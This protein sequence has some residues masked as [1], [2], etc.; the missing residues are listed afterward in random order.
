[1]RT[2][3]LL[4]KL[5]AGL[6]VLLLI[7]AGAAILLLPRLLPAERV[8]AMAQEQAQK[9]LHRQVRLGEVSLSLWK[10]IGLRELEL[11]ESPDFSAGTFAAVKELTL[12]P[13]L[14]AL[15]RKQLLID[16]VAIEGLK[17]TLVK[18]K[19]GSFNFSSLGASDAGQDPQTGSGK[20]L[21]GGAGAALALDIRKAKL[22]KS[23]ALYKDLR[24]GDELSLSGMDATL[25]DF[26]LSKP[27]AAQLRLSAKGRVQGR[28]LNGGLRFDG[29]VD[30]G[31]QDPDRLAVF[32]NDLE[33]QQAELRLEASGQ[34]RSL[35]APRFEL[36]AEVKAQGQELFEGDFSG[37]GDAQG[38]ASLKFALRSRGF[39][40]DI[41]KSLGVKGGIGVPRLNAQGAL[42]W[43][44]ARLAL[45]KV[46]LESTPYGNV[47][48]DGEIRGL[49]G[50][51]PFPALDWSVALKIPAG[52][53]KDLGL[54]FPDGIKLPG[55]A[56]D[57]KGRISGD[58]LNV[59]RFRLRTEGGNDV[60]LQG[61]ISGL[62]AAR[63]QLNV[64]VKADS[65]NL[66]ELAQLSP[67]ARSMGLKGRGFFAVAARGYSDRPTLH[68][69]IQFKG[70]G[71][72]A[73]A[74]E[75]SDFAGIAIFDSQRI[76]IPDLKGRVGEGVL[77]LDLTVR[78]YAQAPKIELQGELSR[79]DL[80]KMQLAQGGGKAG[81]AVEPPGPARP[82]PTLEAKGKFTVKEVVHPNAQ[83][84]DMELR[85]DLS[86]VTSDLR[87]LSGWAKMKTGGGRFSALSEM[88]MRSKIIKVLVM[89]LMVFQKVGSLGG[90]RIIPDLNNIAFTELSGDYSFKQGM[91]TIQESRLESEAANLYA[92]GD[93]DL[94]AERLNLAVTAQVAGLNPVE[95]DVRGTF[96]EPSAKPRLGKLLADP[97]KQ[98][99]EKTGKELL[100]N[101]FKRR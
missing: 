88:T 1:M 89:P 96:S 11:S 100:E 6:A 61:L 35:S 59:E 27:F 13:D 93:I 44:G 58:D 67:D 14:F 2:L 49:G 50:P 48:I 18:R 28:P 34:I 91:M 62:R 53:A 41:L 71:A 98:L 85:W 81:K 66:E 10:G 3:G 42:D 99:I 29:K 65:F 80:G 69:K 21:A 39:S 76:D 12:K 22:S 46:R 38:A 52:A 64:S 72:K 68:G 82:L 79:L 77:N 19:D 23:S 15:L 8:R 5:S 26:S 24:S 78:Q 54:T 94:L 37:T 36:K 20:A 84:K 97:A 32:I 63:R 86:G 31:G 87:K 92:K 17:L 25:R 73:S 30:L 55:A 33:L 9:T 75:L 57:G 7:L 74:V 90:L 4:A 40:T 70:L 56:V 95:I 45:R 43:K 47:D 51:A 16:S 101:I 60:E 83:A